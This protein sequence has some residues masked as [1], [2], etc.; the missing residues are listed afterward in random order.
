ML[1]KTFYSTYELD[2]TNKLI[3]RLNGENP[4]TSFF[5][6]DK[7]WRRYAEIRNL[8]VG[9]RPLVIRKLTDLSL[10]S[11][12]QSID[13]T[14]QSDHSDWEQDKTHPFHEDGAEHKVMS[15]V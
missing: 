3:R 5:G 12:I 4:P 14:H 9:E 15:N 10:L 7:R 13:E 1:I 11:V 2:P 8:E 6:E